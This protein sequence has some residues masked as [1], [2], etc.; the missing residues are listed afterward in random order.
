MIEVFNMDSNFR[1]VSCQL[2]GLTLNGIVSQGTAIDKNIIKID[3]AT[4][5]QTLTKTITTKF[6]QVKIGTEQY[7]LPLYQ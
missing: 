2:G 1:K 6:L 5:A 4:V 7:Y 3:D